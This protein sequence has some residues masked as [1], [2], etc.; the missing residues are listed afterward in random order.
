MKKGIIA[1]LFLC[2]SLITL[3]ISGQENI[4]ISS[5]Q[6]VNEGIEFHDK[7]EYDKAIS[8]YQKVSKCDPNYGLA[9][10]ELAL[11][12]Y[13]IDKNE[14]ALA[15]CKEALSF[16]YKKATVYSLMGSILDDTGK[17][18]E[19]IELLTAALKEWPFNQNIL[20]N[21]AICY[22]NTDRPVQAEDVLKKSILINPYHTRTHL[23]LAKANYMMGRITQSYLAYNMVMLLNP[24]V[25]N[26][27]S[28][29]EAIS[30]RPKLKNQEYKY[31]Y[32]KNVN[33]A[34]WDEIKWLLQSELAFNK[35][36][37]YDFEY[38][39]TTGRQSLMLLRKLTFE[40]TDTSIYNRLYARLFVDIYQKAGFETYLNYILKNIK[41]DNV[42]KWSNKNQKKLDSL[43]KLA[44]SFLDKG[45]LYGFSYQDEQRKKQTYHYDEKGNLASIGELS[46]KDGNDKNGIWLIIGDDGYISEKGTYLNNKAEKEWLVYWPDG[47][48][49]NRLNFVNDKLEG[50]NK[51]FYPNGT[52][53]KSFNSK[54]GKK[55]GIYENY[56]HSGFLVFKNN[57][58]DDQANGT[59]VYYNY[60]DGFKREYTYNQDTLENE[61]I[62]KWLNGN[63]KQHCSYHKGMIDGSFTTWYKNSSKE[64]E[65]NYKNDILVGKYYEY[66]PNNKKSKELEYNEK[67]LTIGKVITYDR[68]GNITSEE[69]EYL[70]GKLTGTRI[71]FFP[72]GKS[73]RILRYNND[74][75][76]EIVC[77][78]DKGNQ[79]YKAMDADSSIYL[80]SFY[81]DGI[82]SSEG[83][84]VKDKRQG[85]W[86]FYNP[87][88]IITTESNYSNGLLE[89][90]Q[91]T[92]YENGQI[93]KEYT[94]SGNYILGGYKEYYINGHLKTQGNYDSTG[95][96]GKWLY[97][98]NN[99]TLNNIIFYKNGNLVG[100]SYTFDPD[101]HLKSEEFHNN[102]GISIQDKEYDSDG[103]ISA[104]MN[105]EY[106]SHTFE[107]NFPNGKL[108][109][110]KNFSDNVL[111][112]FQET[113]YPNGQ[114]ATQIEYSHN[115]MN[116]L[117]KKWDYNGNITYEIPYILGLAEGEGKWY[118]DNNLEYEAH[119]EQN[120]LQ[121][122]TTSYYYNSQKARESMYIDDNR[123][124]NSDYFSPEGFFMYRIRYV[125]NTVKAYS[126]LNKSGNMIPEVAITDTTRKIKT[127]YQ[128]GKVSAIISLYKGLY[129]GKLTSFYTSG[130]LLRESNFKFDENEGYD[131]TY[132]PNNKLRELINYTSDSRNGLYELYYENGRKQKSG[133][134]FMGNEAGEWKIYN[135]DGSIKELITYRNGII[136][137]I[138]K[139]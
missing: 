5:D 135:T 115:L 82:V 65:K 40:P 102:E 35:D 7:G 138:K 98:Y 43:V 34:K 73:Q 25:N 137:D 74:H 13:Y 57:Y 63:E 49:K 61:N 125:D 31:P 96:A 72:D 24:S 16:N 81:T 84:L 29:E 121:G 62:E 42:I 139:R 22:L 18:N 97:Y 12:L 68:M 111:H 36:F 69:S 52:L 1:S 58:S 59:G 108:K 56:T 88:G 124:G 79:L 83:L 6:F 91:N 130:S 14:D 127:Y 132:Y 21:L 66:Y 71:E 112:G 122:K 46:G 120:K 4:Y 87:L 119:Y 101:G 19:G 33:S 27:A 47:T 80:K 30:Q 109:D 60:N 95:V 75:L 85:K 3:R 105:F 128:N 38:N 20:Y 117:Y 10:Y 89:G 23:G 99:D 9:C 100:R 110:R 123:N 103:T 26:I 67:G 106:G 90:I 131:K 54:S 8:S 104:D 116:G 77:L 136:Y 133:N 41:N 92:Y 17:E 93:G 134:Y 45:R 129:H 15:K 39:Y 114:T 11:T 64:S 86:K 51:I 78:D 32:A 50:T 2:F 48:I 53:E 55:E 126:Y 113:Y 37:D 107:I 44:Q 76:L 94:A 70:D 28:F 118:K